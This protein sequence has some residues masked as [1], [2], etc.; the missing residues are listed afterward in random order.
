[1]ESDSVQLSWDTVQRLFET[2]QKLSRCS[3]STEK[4]AHLQQLID[5]CQ[6]LETAT[7]TCL[8]QKLVLFLHSLLFIYLSSCGILWCFEFVKK[9]NCFFINVMF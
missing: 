7:T 1:M 4:L 5:D 2:G 9:T 3:T 8:T 6:K